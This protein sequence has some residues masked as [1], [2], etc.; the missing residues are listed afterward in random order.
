MQM[1][2]FNVCNNININLKLRY[3]LR[4]NNTMIHSAVTF[5]HSLISPKETK[6]CSTI[7]EV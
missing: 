5:L 1:F 6:G 2:L 4:L 3:A 7:L